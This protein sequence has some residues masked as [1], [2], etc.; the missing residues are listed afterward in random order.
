MSNLLIRNLH[1]YEIGK[2]GTTYVD[3]DK[4]RDFET[5][6]GIVTRFAQLPFVNIT[7]LHSTPDVGFISSETVAYKKVR[8][9]DTEHSTRGTELTNND[10]TVHD[11]GRAK[12]RGIEYSS[13]TASGVFMSTSTLTTN[14]YKQY[15]FD[16]EMFAHLNVRG[17]ASGALTTGETLTGG[18]S[19]VTAKVIGVD[20]TDGTDPNTLYVKYENSGTNNTETKLN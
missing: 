5:D 1:G 3:V 19:G 15:L 11:I 12:T 7:E 9:V 6:S 13:G 16:V 8:L 10:G 20:A 17:P 14:T 2:I 18:T 4:A